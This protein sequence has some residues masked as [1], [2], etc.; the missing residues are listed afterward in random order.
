MTLDLHLDVARWRR[1]LDHMQAAVPG[2]VPVIKGNGY[3]FGLARLAQEAQRMGAAEVGVGMASEVAVVRS[4]GFQ[5]D[6]VVL[7]P[8]SSTE[9]GWEV[10]DDPAVI[11]TVGRLDDAALLAAQHPGARVIVELQTSMRRFGIGADDLPHL[12]DVLADLDLRGYTIHLPMAADD[13][14]QEALELASQVR[15]VLPAPLWLSHIPLTD[16]QDLAAAHPGTRLRLGTDLWLGERQSRWITA[17]VLDV[18]PIGRGE[19][20][21]YWHRRSPIDGWV[22]VMSGGTSHGLGMEAPVSG[23][24]L[25]GRLTSVVM[26]SMEAAGWARS[27]YTIAG[28]KRFFVEPPHMQ[29]SLV[30]LPGAGRVAVGQE[31][32]VQLRMTTATFDRVIEHRVIEH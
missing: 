10:L 11:V 1:H 18:H 12:A 13:R 3:G 17:T 25:R 6:V 21:G 16:Y 19:H 32:P 30:F 24:S 9:P 31:V 29:S 23:R 4:A 22:L 7:T 14:V 26:S 15:D 27:P 8:L 5:G 20:V 2:L 28:R